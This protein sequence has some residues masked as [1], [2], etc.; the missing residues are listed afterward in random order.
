MPWSVIG[1]N[2]VFAMTTSALSEIIIEVLFLNSDRLTTTDNLSLVFEYKQRLCQLMLQEFKS[3]SPTNL[4]SYEI[5]ETSDEATAF[6]AAAMAFGSFSGFERLIVISK[7]PYLV[8]A[9]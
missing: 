3:A 5:Y 2:S 8:G 7:S 4:E 9:L 6:L 1:S